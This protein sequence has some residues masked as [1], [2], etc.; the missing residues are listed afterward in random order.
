MPG[1]RMLVVQLLSSLL[2]T[3]AAVLVATGSVQRLAC[4]APQCPFL[5]PLRYR[6]SV[7]MPG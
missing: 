6:E 4:H 1:H 2:L 5:E 7:H 3:P